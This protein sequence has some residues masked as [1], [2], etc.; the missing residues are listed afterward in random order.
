MDIPATPNPAPAAPATLVPEHHVK[1]AVYRRTIVTFVLTALVVQSS[2]S[3]GASL[4]KN[5]NKESKTLVAVNTQSTGKG[6]ANFECAIDP[7][8]GVPNW[9][10]MTS[11]D[12]LNRKYAAIGPSEYVYPPQYNIAELQVPLKELNE[13]EKTPENVRLITDKLFYSTRFMG[14]YDLD[15]GEFTGT[16]SGIDYKMP[17]GTPIRAIAGG[18]VYAVNKE[19]TGLGNSVTIEH[20]LPKTGERVFSIYGHMETISAKV[21]D[22][23]EPGFIIGTV[24]S[25]GDSTLPHLHLQIDRDNGTEPHV[26]YVPLA[27]TPRAEAL[28]WLVN[29]VDFIENN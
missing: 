14:S 1:R 15:A 19:K 17:Q 4:V 8:G 16:H 10:T 2:N 25:T 5:A 23:V 11:T 22:V 12:Q 21:G 29:P 27:T 28:K 6:I 7:F 9:G 20:K 26:P 18:R 13:K 24:G 3:L